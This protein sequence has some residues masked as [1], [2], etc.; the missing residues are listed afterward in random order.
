MSCRVAGL[1]LLFTLNTAFAAPVPK[2]RRRIMDLTGTTWVSDGET[3]FGQTIYKFLPNGVL[4]YQYGGTT[5]RNGVWK[6]DGERFTY[7]LN[8]RYYW[9]EGEIQGDVIRGKAA[10]KPGGNWTYQLKLSPSK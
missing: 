8:Q 10:N 4:E 1:V 9:Y 6:A 2:E 5:W 3:G 7:E